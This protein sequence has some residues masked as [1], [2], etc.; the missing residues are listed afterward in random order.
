MSDIEQVLHQVKVLRE[1]LRVSR[2]ELYER[3][4]ELRTWLFNYW[5]LALF[6]DVIHVAFTFELPGTCHDE[7]LF[8]DTARINYSLMT[9][10]VGRHIHLSHT[11]ED[12]QEN[13]RITIATV[14]RIFQA[15][16]YRS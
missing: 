10:K 11:M 4:E 7:S 3:K 12:L 2:N 16:K 8:T 9:A 5:Q 15:F 14:K 13:S 6:E 1:K